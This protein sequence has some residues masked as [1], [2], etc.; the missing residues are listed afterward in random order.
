MTELNKVIH[1]KGLI[2][3]R[4]AKLHNAKNASCEEERQ[5]YEG[6]AQRMQKHIDELRPQ[7]EKLETKLITK[8]HHA[9]IPKIQINYDFKD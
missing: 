5:M 9:G 7:A 1:Y 8:L 3:Y 6:A 4:D 2:K